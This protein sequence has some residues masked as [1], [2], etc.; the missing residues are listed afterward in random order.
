MRSQHVSPLVYRPSERALR[1]ARA[2]ARRSA[3]TS[4]MKAL[5]GLLRG[6][7]AAMSA[8]FRAA[9]D[10]ARRAAAGVTHA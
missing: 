7:A 3:T 8:H 4:L 10:D 6:D 5:V 2:E 1:A 9:Q